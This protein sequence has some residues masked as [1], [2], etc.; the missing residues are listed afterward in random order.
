MDGRR[1]VHRRVALRQRPGAALILAG[2][3]EAEQ[4]EQRVGQADHPAARRLGDTEVVHEGPGV[5]L[6]QLRDLRLD[7]AG[8]GHVGRRL[9]Q[10]ARPSS[11]SRAASPSWSSSMLSTTSTGFWVRKRKPRSRRSSSASRPKP[12][13]LAVGQVRQQPIQQRLFQRALLALGGRPMATGGAQ[14][15]QPLLDHAQVGDRELELQ[16]DV[17]PRIN[18]SLGRAGIEGAATC[19]S[20]SALRIW[21]STSGWMVP[22]GP[23]RRDRDV[24]VGD[25][26]GVV[27]LVE[28]LGEAIQSLIG[29]LDDRDVGEA[30]AGIAADLGMPAG[31][32]V[33]D[34]AFDPGRPTMVTCTA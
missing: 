25:V 6:R 13:R 17:A 4:A 12:Q 19:S 22:R 31:Q 9:G 33:E 1:R 10:R 29:H 8:Q 34:G 5:V 16:L 20:A 26:G 21:A 27:F 3:E 32:G 2:G 11:S 30:A 14:L 23:R 18:R 15:L 7:L 28:Q 24:H